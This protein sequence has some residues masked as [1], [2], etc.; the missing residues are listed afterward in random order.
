MRCTLI[1][2]AL[3]VCAPLGPASAGAEPIDA[4][5]P[6]TRE[7][8]LFI[9]GAGGAAE[10]ELPGSARV[11]VSAF[12][13]FEAIDRWLEIELGGQ[14]LAMDGGREASLDLLFKKPFTLTERLELMIGL[15][16]T[17][18]QTR[19]RS[20]ADRA[21]WGLEAAA[22][23][24]YWPSRH[25]G[26]WLEPAYDVTFSRGVTHALSCTGGPMLGF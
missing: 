15:G 19:Q 17:I 7:G 24:M 1:A 14:V 13:E 23:F 11:G 8:Y 20:E 16:P 18:A 22:D 2:T 3:L 21:S 4:T 9:F 5:S 12:V 25:V 6:P 10:L 26:V